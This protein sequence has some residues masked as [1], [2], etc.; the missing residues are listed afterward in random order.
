M[1]SSILVILAT[2]FL[3][4]YIVFLN[5]STKISGNLSKSVGDGGSN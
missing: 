1:I 5:K 3:I 2:F 4:L